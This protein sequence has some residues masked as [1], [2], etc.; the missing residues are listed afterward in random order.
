VGRTL[1]SAVAV[2]VRASQPPARIGCR[3]EE[4]RY[5]KHPG[6]GICPATAPG[7]PSGVTRSVVMRSD[8]P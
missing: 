1:R 8:G 7:A 2:G 6:L 3:L 5:N 4:I